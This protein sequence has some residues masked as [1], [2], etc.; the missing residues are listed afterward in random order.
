MANSTQPQ[1][2]DEPAVTDADLEAVF[3]GDADAVPGL[4]PMADVMA[5]LTAAPSA[6]EL[7][8]EARALADFRRRVG[9]PRRHRA[10]RGTALL[11]SRLGAKI[12]AAATAVAVAFGSAATAAFAD[13][14]PAPIQRLAHD[15]FGAPVPQPRRGLPDHRRRGAP[16]GTT[17]HGKQA[18]AGR[19][20]RRHPTAVPTPPGNPNPQGQQ[21][22]QNAQGKK[23]NSPGEG[24]SS[25]QG[26]ASGQD[27]ERGGGGHAVA[28]RTSQGPAP[29]GVRPG[30]SQPA[31]HP[32]RS[33]RATP[34]KGP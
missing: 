10:R 13:D 7:A 6:A 3:A 22:N 24:Q 27:H 15:A 2:Q 1:R 25:G 34:A 5:A 14:L 17:A 16:R 18:Q 30:Q 21:G 11:P 20:P 31:R 9:A 19:H 26:Q 4:R 8:A 32:R 33:A 23:G 28:H 12:G 29:R